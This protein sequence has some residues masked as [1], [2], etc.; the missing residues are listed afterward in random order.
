MELYSERLTE[1]GKRKAD[2]KFVVDVLLLFRP[3]IIRPSEG[4]KNV[5][6]YA[7]YKSYFKIGWR[8]LLR[9]KGY[10]F[11]NIGGLAIGM[12]VAILI[13]LWIFDELSFNKYHKNYEKIVQIRKG[14][15]YEG[16]FYQ[17]QRY[18]PFPLIEELQTNYAANFKHIVPYQG[19][20]NFLTVGEKT[21]SQT[22]VFAGEGVQAR[23]T[24][25][26][27]SDRGMPAALPADWNR[28]R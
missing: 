21:I 3:G 2:L 11:I 24:S 25:R 5:N 4:Y 17:G 23:R 1:E 16:K 20:D 8:N 14:G 22:G 9:N 10:S 12:M 27:D 26:L 28:A 18:M 13:G 7:M 19:G 15:T 6:Q